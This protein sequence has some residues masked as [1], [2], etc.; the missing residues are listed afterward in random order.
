MARPDILD[1]EFGKTEV[2]TP[3]L[4]NLWEQDG[5][6]TFSNPW[7][8]KYARIQKDRNDEIRQAWAENQD[9]LKSL[10]PDGPLSYVSTLTLSVPSNSTLF[11]FH[12]WDHVSDHICDLFIKSTKR[13]NNNPAGT[14]GSLAEGLGFCPGSQITWMWLLEM[15]CCFVK[16]YYESWKGELKGEKCHWIW[17][18]IWVSWRRF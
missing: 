18:V 1:T 9:Y 15:F 12:V 3:L 16:C 2:I 10:K 4:Q 6:N 14:S 7:G 5:N 17:K 8:N 11:Q 13:K